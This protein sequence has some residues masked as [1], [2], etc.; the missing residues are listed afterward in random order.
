MRNRQNR[1]IR[2]QECQANTEPPVRMNAQHQVVTG[3]DSQA[4]KVANGKAW[5]LLNPVNA[6]RVVGTCVHGQQTHILES[7]GIFATISERPTILQL[8]HVLQAP[9][10]C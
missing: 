8:M 6:C 9:A 10:S 7:F 1:Q 4:P 2:G 5:L 3:V